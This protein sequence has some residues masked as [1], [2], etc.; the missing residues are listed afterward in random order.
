MARIRTIKPDFF[1]SEDIVSLTAFARLLYIGLWC[2][3]DR[4]GRFAWK[5][6]TF[7]IRYLPADNCNIAK[8]CQELVDRGVVVL[9]GDGLA[10]IPQFLAHQHINPR[11]AESI[12]PEPDASA[13]VTDASNLEL[14]AQVG[15]KGKERKEGETRGASVPLAEVVQEYHEALPSCLRVE[16]IGGE[17]VRKF[18]KVEKLAR[19]LC[20]DRGWE[21]DR[22]FWRDFFAECAKDPWYR[23]EVANPKNASWKQSLDVLL[24]EDH[25]TKI[26]ELAL[27]GAA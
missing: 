20:A 7:K 1:T 14:H 21:Y 27:A 22:G 23:G 25:F 4:E 2:E 19:R 11:E 26:M 16:V 6:G 15:R 18:A 12:L 24:R 13:R 3:A 9:Y 10:F 17:R 8:L 5:P